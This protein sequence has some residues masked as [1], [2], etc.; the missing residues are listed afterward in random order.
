MLMSAKSKVLNK[1]LSRNKKA[2]QT[3]INLELNSKGF[4]WLIDYKIS[5][6]KLTEEQKLLSDELWLKIKEIDL[7]PHESRV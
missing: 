7:H 5:H 1:W 4:D 2:L 3:F 6:N